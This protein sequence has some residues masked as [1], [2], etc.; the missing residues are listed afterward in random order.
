[1]TALER[2]RLRSHLACEPEGVGGFVIWDQ[3]RL[4]VHHLRVT[5]LEMS[6]LR[7]FDGQ[8]TVAGY[9]GRSPAEHS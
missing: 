6:W 2:P 3:L 1:M 7:L 5:N 9:S 4:A 8:R